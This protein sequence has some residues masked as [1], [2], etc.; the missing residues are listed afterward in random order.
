MKKE[1]IIAIALGL[2]VGALLFGGIWTANQALQG[3]T[4]SLLSANA[5]SPTNLPPESQNN[6]GPPL[7]VITP[8]DFTLTKSAKISLTGKTLPNTNIIIQTENG[9][10]YQ[11]SDDQG[12]FSQ[13]V[14][15]NL[16]S[17]DLSVTTVAD[18]GDTSTQTV[19]VVYSTA[20][21]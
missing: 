19:T 6:Q 1:V 17:N 10:V 15:L 16:G 20:S 2:F 4:P 14:S 11:K 9:A 21:L 5:T 18:S 12:T 8:K 7:N 13:D 3:S